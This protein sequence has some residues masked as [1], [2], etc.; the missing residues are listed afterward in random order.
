MQTAETAYNL[1]EEIDRAEEVGS[2]S[3][4]ADNVEKHMLTGLEISVESLIRSEKI[5]DYSNKIA[6]LLHE[7]THSK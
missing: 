6:T 1:V 4:T 2:D 5:V 3:F 7:Y